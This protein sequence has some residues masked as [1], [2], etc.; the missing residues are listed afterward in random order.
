MNQEIQIEN[1]A[2]VKSNKMIKLILGI[3]FDAT[4]MIPS[5]FPP[6]AF[7]WAPLSAFIMTRMYKGNVGKIAGII[8]FLEEIFPIVD[9]IPTFTLTW[10]YV[11]LIK[12]EK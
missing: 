4:G 7:I 8:D 6:I 10:V 1:K 11:Y 5:A 3:I 2:E 12:K 9:V